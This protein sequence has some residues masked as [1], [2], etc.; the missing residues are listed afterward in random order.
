M[1][2][3]C[4]RN[5]CAEAQADHNLWNDK[6]DEGDVETRSRLSDASPMEQ[7]TDNAMKQRRED[8]QEGAVEERRDGMRRGRRRKQKELGGDRGETG[9]S[10]TAAEGRRKRHLAA[11]TSSNDRVSGVSS[12]SEEEVKLEPKKR[13]RKRPLMIFLGVS[14]RQ[15]REAEEKMIKKD[16]GKLR[17]K[18]TEEVQASPPT[19]PSQGPSSYANVA[20][21]GESLLPPKQARLRKKRVI[22]DSSSSSENENKKGAATKIQR[23]PSFDDNLPEE[24][25]L[26]A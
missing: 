2:G 10:S 17:K 24:A 8:I 5:I 20:K 16:L 6:P 12:A 23:I 14:F 4:R 25:S 13:P 3:P 1:R 21:G 22:V 26:P 19:L 9:G 15:K 11:Y 18:R 7:R